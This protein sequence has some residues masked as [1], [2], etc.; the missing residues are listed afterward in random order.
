MSYKNLLHISRPR[1]WLYLAG[2]YLLGLAAAGSAL[3]AHE[4]L[5][6]WLYLL[7]F[8][9]PANLLVYGVNDIFDFETDRLNPKKQYY[10][11]LLSPQKQ[12]SLWM[13]ILLLNLPFLFL[14]SVFELPSSTLWAM[15]GFLFFGI[16]YS[17]PPIRA[18][19]KPLLDSAFNVL[20]VFPGL[21]SYYL[22][23]GMGFHW[24]V[25]LASF[26]W[27][28]AMHAFSAVPDIEADKSAGLRTVATFLGKN[29][30]LLFCALCYLG[31]GVLA[32][33]K[34]GLFALVLGIG[35]AGLM[36]V[37]FT[38]KENTRLF[39]VYTWFP[40]INAVVGFMIFLMFAKHS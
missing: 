33:T 16:F 28:M 15:A 13:K 35:Y 20:Y 7:Y 10:E 24:Q 12:K 31:A 40:W 17:A 39:R 36:L 26:F 30:T 5:V 23:G 9:L 6:V 25:F 37:A 14:L 3:N 8:F 32:Q 18:K 29:A 2:P 34:L 1:F 19:T 4:N 21:F 22:L 27:V 38:A 11:T